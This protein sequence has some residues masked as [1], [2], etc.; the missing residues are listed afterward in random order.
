M[1]VMEYM[2]RGPVIATAGQNGFPCFP[3]EVRS[4]GRHYVDKLLSGCGPWGR[5][6]AGPAAGEH[7]LHAPPAPVCISSGQQASHL[8]PNPTYTYASHAHTHAHAHAHAQRHARTR[9]YHHKPP[10]LPH[11]INPLPAGLPGLLPPGVSWAGLPALQ[12]GGARRPQAGEP[13][14]VR[15]RGAQARG[16]WLIQV[17][18]VA[19]RHQLVAG[20]LTLHG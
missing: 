10:A 13:A 9:T 8:A 1:L 18:H 7:P 4:G 6:T 15:H 11:L 3:E 19:Y 12:Q 2:E 17:W 5:W 20:S 14:G 16:L